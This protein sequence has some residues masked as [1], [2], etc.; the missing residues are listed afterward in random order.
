MGLI[1]PKNREEIDKSKPGMHALI[2]GV[3]SYPHLHGG[4]DRLGEYSFGMKQL[5]ASAL[6]AYRIHEWIVQHRNRFR[7]PLASCRFLFSPT[8]REIKQIKQEIKDEDTLRRIDACNL[9]NFL[10]DADEWREDTSGHPCNMTFFYFAGHGLQTNKID[11]ALLLEDFNQPGGG[12]LRCA[13]DIDNIYEGMAPNSSRPRIARKQ[14]YFVDACRRRPKELKELQNVNTT[15]VFTLRFESESE[16]ES[17][18][19]SGVIDDRSAPVIYAAV[20]GDMAYTAPK[21]HTFFSQAL[22]SCLKGRAGVKV[23]NPYGLS[24][25]QVSAYSISAALKVVLD[26]INQVRRL[27]LDH[28]IRGKDVTILLLDGAPNADI[29]LE[30]DPEDAHRVASIEV[31]DNRRSRV[32]QLNPPLPPYP[33]RNALAPGEYRINA[34]INPAKQ[35]YINAIGEMRHAMPPLSHWVI[36]VTKP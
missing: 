18:V 15:D 2:A 10:R 36:R 19:T 7:P 5:T 11:T 24:E 3:S 34:L 35:P 21:Q 30:V 17:G 9:R 31:F 26:E 32:W 16:D 12:A 29:V 28:S 13:V 27:R 22:L 8:D 23:E 14:I 4:K 1:F 25:W 6:S 20:P 33:F